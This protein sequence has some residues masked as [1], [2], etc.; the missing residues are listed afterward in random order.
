M[1]KKLIALFICAF[2]AYYSI[3]SQLPEDDFI[4]QPDNTQFSNKKAFKHIVALG[5]EVHFSGS[6]GH[7]N[8]RN[9]IVNELQKME[10]TPSVQEG[11]SFSDWGNFV[12]AKNI[13]A[14][15]KGANASKDSKAV[16]IMSHYDSSPH[17]SFGAS[18]AGS[19][20][21]MI[22]EGI[23][24]Y[25]A[26][27]KEYKNDIIVMLTDAEELGLNG[28]QLFVNE[29]PWCKDV[30]VILNF[31]ARG[32][33]GPSFT[34][35]ETNKG[36]AALM[37]GFIAANPKYPV[38]NSLAYSIYKML[39][40]DTDLT[41]FRTAANIQGFNFA[42]IDD[43]YDYHSALDIAERMDNNTL[44]HQASY[45]MPLLH[46]FANAD[47]TQLNSDE[48]HV[49][50]NTPL[51]MHSYSF[52]WIPILVYIA[53]A[54]FITLLIYG[55]RTRKLSGK[56]TLKGFGAFL[57]ALVICTAIGALGWKLIGMVYPEYHE[58]LQ[59][60]PYN[61][62][63]YILFF[64]L[65]TLGCCFLIYKKVYD[66][67][68]S[69]ELMIA[70]LFFWILINTFIMLK[71]EGASFFIIPIFFG[72]LL[73]YF[74]IKKEQ[75]DVLA[76]TLLSIPAIIIYTPFIQQFPIALGM[77]IVAV[78]CLLTVLL[79]GLLLPVLGPIRRK[80]LLST[81][82]FIIAAIILVFAHINAPFTP[83]R[84]KP[85]SLLYV[86][87]QDTNQSYFAT[88]DFLLDNWTAPYFN[89][90]DSVASTL[91]FSSKYNTGFSKTAKTTSINLPEADV[92]IEHDS[93][94]DNNRIIHLCI[95]PQRS[96]QTLDI[97][98]N[99]K[100]QFT[101]FEL[102]GTTVP[103]NK[104]SRFFKEGDPKIVTYYFTD[105][106]PIELKLSLPNNVKP[107]L[108][109]NEIAFDL[110]SNSKANVSPRS[111]D[112]IPKPFVVNDATIVQHSVDFN[113]T[114][115]IVIDSLQHQ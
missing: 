33:G 48:D 25:L 101:H 9:Y 52:K 63:W 82:F 94:V 98:S 35:L 68:N 27:N 51:G 40:N 37:N 49:Y 54:L 88:Y 57:G 114:K 50:F 76:T 23:R 21:A 3:H 12:H 28:A 18:D 96:L 78:S 85:N 113:A 77:K 62:H 15:V 29:H 55:F 19:G 109:L 16:M 11:N 93:I 61:G 43:H 69:K 46:Y 20:V 87:N 75:P 44:S 104:K 41:V 115:E 4:D 64:V 39:P 74:L 42:F 97:R 86:Q 79:F 102:N 84:P 90:K 6:S 112:M 45:L 67:L 34:L 73:F 99:T 8:V 13:L 59:G 30:G 92:V 110:L 7:T 47:L 105:D 89:Q 111:N 31:E 1:I 66:P 17:S 60:F 83:E 95:T 56:E 5:E 108:E 100:S 70:P 36:N 32:S 26:S 38:A 10:L 53:L 22:L 81:C 58:I 80:K 107:H 71:L 24:S 72:L 2:T 14:R 103:T 91:L 65:L 106:K